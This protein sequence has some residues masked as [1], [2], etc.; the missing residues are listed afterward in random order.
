ML[1][2]ASPF[3]PTLPA[4]AG[5]L[6][7]GRRRG[8]R[9]PTR[10]EL[11]GGEND[12]KGGLD[13]EVVIYV[14]D[15]WTVAKWW[16]SHGLPWVVIEPGPLYDFKWARGWIVMAITREKFTG[17]KEWIKEQGASVVAHVH[18]PD[19]LADIEARARA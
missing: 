7:R 6:A 3:V 11:R 10:A 13:H 19:R 1:G 18:D 15:S 16:R 2:S 4:F 9:P 14:T 17:L 8:M 12:P 5:E